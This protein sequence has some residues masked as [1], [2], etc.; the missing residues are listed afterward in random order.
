MTS[1]L[2]E[3]DE[4]IKHLITQVTVAPDGLDGDGLSNH[5]NTDVYG[6]ALCAI[7]ALSMEEWCNVL[8]PKLLFK[9]WHIGL[10][11]T[12][13]HSRL[14]HRV[15]YIMFWPLVNA[16]TSTPWSSQV[17]NVMGTIL[18]W[19][20]VFWS[21]IYSQV[22]DG[23]SFYWQFQLWLIQPIRK[24]SN[25]E[26]SVIL[27]IQNAS[28][29]P[30]IGSENTPEEVYGQFYEMCQCYCTKQEQVVFHSPWQTLAEAAI[31]ELKVGIHNAL[32]QTQVPKHTWCYAGI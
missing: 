17:S 3:S 19:Y 6:D 23:P 22:Q 4:F 25:M 7:L 9:C 32:H 16:S 2:L 18:H 26:F 8:M 21:Q 31:H 13:T 20:D 27:F 15:A 24:K 5:A 30:I 29:P 12:K 10:M 11:A 28:I 14:Q 1:F